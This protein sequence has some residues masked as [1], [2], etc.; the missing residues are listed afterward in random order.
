MRKYQKRIEPSLI[1]TLDILG[2]T[3]MMT[4]ARTE[5]LSDLACS[6]ENA[7]ETASLEVSKL[8]SLLDA[9]SEKHLRFAKSFKLRVFSDTLVISCDFDNI[10]KTIP[11]L[12]RLN[13]PEYLLMIYGFFVC[14][15][16]LARSLFYDGYPTRGCI[17]SGPVVTTKN[18]VIGRPFVESLRISKDLN[19]A[20]IVLTDSAKIIYDSVAS[21]LKALATDTTIEPHYVNCKSSPRKRQNCLNLLETREDRHLIELFPSLFSSHGKLI[22]PDVQDKITN[23]RRLFLAFLKTIKHKDRS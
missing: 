23:T 11:P 16:S 10:F 8:I 21:K 13:R 22:T 15:K 12:S 18:F 9:T 1:A 17:A 4:E 14:V 20:G 2:T 7:Y 3:R 5:T 6:L 19:F